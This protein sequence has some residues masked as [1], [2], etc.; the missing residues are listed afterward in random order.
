MEVENLKIDVD[1]YALSLLDDFVYYA[2]TYPQ[3]MAAAMSYYEDS[4]INRTRILKNAFDE[5]M[6]EESRRRY[7]GSRAN[8]WEPYSS[9]F[10][11]LDISTRPKRR[12]VVR[13]VIMELSRIRSKEVFNLQRI[14]ANLQDSD[15]AAVAEGSIDSLTDAINSLVG[16]Y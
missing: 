7:P 6:D 13:L 3:K 10:G 12:F 14:P 1:G 5:A 11:V 16:A 4:F 9:V 15:A 2:S 8:N